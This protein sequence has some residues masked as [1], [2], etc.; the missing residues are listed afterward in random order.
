L[1]AHTFKKQASGSSWKE[2]AAIVD[3]ADVRMGLRLRKSRILL[4]ESNDSLYHFQLSEIGRC[5]PPSF[6]EQIN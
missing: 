4:L 1:T 2:R 3:D 5:G 6:G